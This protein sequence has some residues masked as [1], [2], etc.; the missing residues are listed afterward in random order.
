MPFFLNYSLMMTFSK[1]SRSWHYQKWWPNKSEWGSSS[2]GTRHPCFGV[3]KLNF[4]ST[5]LPYR[6]VNLLHW[7]HEE[8]V[9]R[10]E[11]P[12][13]GPRVG[14]CVIPENELWEGTHEL[15]ELEILWRKG[16]LG[17][18]QGG[19]GTQNCSAS[20]LAAGLLWWWDEFPGCL[21][22]ITLMKGPSC[23]CPPVLLGQGGFQQGG[24]W[25]VGRACGVSFQPFPNVPV[26]CDLLVPCSLPEPLFI[27]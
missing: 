5:H 8:S 17:R 22:L 13:Q 26:G 4:E 15:T 24:S 10:R 11:S 27:R 12:W 6:K 7:S 16:G 3:T 20:W 19:E 21:W 14:S 18:E 2:V 1:S 9:A 25:E 23:W